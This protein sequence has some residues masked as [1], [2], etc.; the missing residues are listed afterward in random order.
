LNR[1]NVKPFCLI[2]SLFSK[3]FFVKLNTLKN[4]I[5]ILAWHL[6]GQHFCRLPNALHVFASNSLGRIGWHSS[7]STEANDQ[8]KF[9]RMA[10]P[11]GCAGSSIGG[12]IGHFAG[13]NFDDILKLYLQNNIQVYF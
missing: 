5:I 7:I 9:G 8:R 6:F 11:I 3:P 1:L 10:W 13:A 2:F 4:K 12:G